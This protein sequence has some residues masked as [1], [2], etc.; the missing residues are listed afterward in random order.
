MW[1]SGS[2]EDPWSGALWPEWGRASRG[3]KN[4]ASAEAPRQQTAKHVPVTEKK[5]E[6]GS[7]GWDLMKGVEG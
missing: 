4:N 3:K 5:K 6:K 2:W 7:S 1:K